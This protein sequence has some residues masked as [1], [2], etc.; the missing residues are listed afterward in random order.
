M[1]YSEIIELALGYADRSDAE[2]TDRMD[3]FLKLVEARVN[4]KL[5]VRKMSTRSQINTVEG[6]AYYGLP[7]DFNGLRDIEIAGDK[8]LTLRYLTPEQM[9]MQ[10][11]TSTDA[12]TQIYYTI[13]ADQL[14]IHPTQ[15]DNVLEIVYYQMLPA[16]TD[17]D[18]ENWLSFVAPDA[19]VFGLLVEINSFVKDATTAQLWDG[20]FEQV[21][22]ELETDDK[23]DRWSGTPL[24]V[25]VT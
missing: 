19:Y 6:Q 9:N 18:I 22:D 13:V 2:V 16:L 11:Q 4:R 10:T 12:Y 15:S 3:D 1:N 24:Q 20:R 23:D 17:V 8:T 14:Q 21:M 25:R 7:T 5:E